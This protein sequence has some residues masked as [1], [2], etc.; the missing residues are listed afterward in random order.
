MFIS[1]EQ[2]SR[3]KKEVGVGGVKRK[4]DREVKRESGRDNLK[5]KKLP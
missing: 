1:H 4:T 5:K 2:M 3:K